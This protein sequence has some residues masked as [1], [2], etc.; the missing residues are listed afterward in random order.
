MAGIKFI[1]DCCCC[2]VCSV[3]AEVANTVATTNTRRIASINCLELN[4][5]LA[6]CILVAGLMFCASW[7]KLSSCFPDEMASSI[8]A[9]WTCYLAA[10]FI[11][12]VATIMVGTLCTQDGHCHG[13]CCVSRSNRTYKY[14]SERF[15]LGVSGTSP[16]AIYYYGSHTGTVR[17]FQLK[18]RV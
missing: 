9:D 7:I 18:P 14:S 6:Y 15:L 3:P 5:L 1:H 16:P 10:G 11:W 8:V 12:T 13:P 4:C 17:I 2:V